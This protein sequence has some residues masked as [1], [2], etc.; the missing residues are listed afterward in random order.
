MP[1][2]SYKTFI[3]ISLHSWL[4]VLYLGALGTVLAFIWYAQAIHAIGA[5]K[6]IIF[7]NLVPI[8]AVLVA[9]FILKEPITGSMAVGAVLSFIGILLVNKY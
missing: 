9:F 4:A 1:E 3:N 7:T 5:S 8:F 2:L 6:T